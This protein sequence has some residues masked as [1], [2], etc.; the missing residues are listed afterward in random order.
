MIMVQQVKERIFISCYVCEYGPQK[1]SV[2]EIASYEY[3]NFRCA[4]RWSPVSS[5]YLTLNEGRAE[6]P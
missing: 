6:L 4:A 2:S 3:N 1:V 5:D